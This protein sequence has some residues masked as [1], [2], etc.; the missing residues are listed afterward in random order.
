MLYGRCTGCADRLPAENLQACLGACAQ[1]SAHAP[2]ASERFS[3]TPNQGKPPMNGMAH[4]RRGSSGNKSLCG[5]SNKGGERVRSFVPRKH[6]Q[7][8]GHL[9]ESAL[10]QGARE[11]SASGPHRG[12]QA[13]EESDMWGGRCRYRTWVRL[14][15]D[16]GAIEALE[17]NPRDEGARVYRPERPGIREARPAV[18][19]ERSVHPLTDP[20]GRHGM[21]PPRSAVQTCRSDP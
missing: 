3:R 17:A 16:L 7:Q 14:S 13:L 4:G 9:A 2:T 18:G 10:P 15:A 20:S 5:N 21:S 19:G 8:E 12:S 1:L 11:G 6:G